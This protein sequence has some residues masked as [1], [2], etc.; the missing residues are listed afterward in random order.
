MIR[1]LLRLLGAALPALV[2]QGCLTT[3]PPSTVHQPMTARPVPVDAPAV[4]N[5]SIYQAN[6]QPQAFYGYR[7]LFEDRRARMVGDTLVVAINE[8]TAASKQSNSNAERK[9]SNETNNS[10]DNLALLRL[11]RMPFN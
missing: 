1:N 7:P 11:L 9:S 10:Q 4:A 6:Y 3:T 8:K 5:G 2:L